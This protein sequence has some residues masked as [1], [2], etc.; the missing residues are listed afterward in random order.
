V[1]LVLPLRATSLRVWEQLPL[2]QERQQ[3]LMPGWHRHLLQSTRQQQWVRLQAA[4][5]AAVAHGAAAAL[6]AAGAARR[7]CEAAVLRWRLLLW[8]LLASGW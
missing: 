8:Q 4:A 1:P 7:C 5:T 6:P 3:L 2:Q